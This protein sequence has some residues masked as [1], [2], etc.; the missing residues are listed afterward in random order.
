MISRSILAVFISAPSFT[1]VLHIFVSP[2]KWKLPALERLHR[3]D[4]ARV[5]VRKKDAGT[6]VLLY[7]AQSVP[8]SSQPCVAL[9]KLADIYS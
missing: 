6:I 2:H 7:Q 9:G 8:V 4:Q 3:L 5:L 1:T